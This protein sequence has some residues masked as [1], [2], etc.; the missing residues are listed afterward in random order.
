MGTGIKYLHSPEPGVDPG[1]GFG[2]TQ[3]PGEVNGHHAAAVEGRGQRPAKETASVS[4]EFL[5]GVRGISGRAGLVDQR[6][7]AWSLLTPC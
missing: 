6:E 7:T 1:L 5:S 2:Q 3:P 4:M